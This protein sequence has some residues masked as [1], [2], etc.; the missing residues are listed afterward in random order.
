MDENCGV[1]SLFGV[2]AAVIQH[3]RSSPYF[4]PVAQSRPSRL[5]TSEGITLRPLLAICSNL[6]LISVA[7][8]P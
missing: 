4:P 7:R 6:L 3:V 2:V 1:L 8:V 5:W